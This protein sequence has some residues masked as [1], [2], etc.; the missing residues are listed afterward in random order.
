MLPCD[1]FEA[2]SIFPDAHEQHF[3]FEVGEMLP[4]TDRHIRIQ[5]SNLIDE[6][7]HLQVRAVETCA[8]LLEVVRVHPI[9]E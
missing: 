4:D 5:L 1:N 9:D 8:E 3:L 7:K 6:S 2:L